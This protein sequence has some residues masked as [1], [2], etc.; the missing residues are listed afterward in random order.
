MLKSASLKLPLYLIICIIS[1]SAILIDGCG[2]KNDDKTTTN[3][4]GKTNNNT[5]IKKDSISGKDKVQLKYVVKKGDILR[6]KMVAKTST[7]ENSPAT[8]NKEVKQDN[9]INYYYSKE[10]TD[11]DQNGIITFKINFDSITISSSMGDQNV[12]YNS[13]V[14]D[15]VKSNPAFIQYNAVIREPFYN[16]VSPQGEITDVYGLEKIYDNLFKAFGDT[17]KEADKNE[18]KESF[19]KESIKEILQQEY[20]IFPAQDVMVDSSWV[21]SYATQLMV[22]EI[23]NNAKYTLKGIEDKDNSKIA[24]IEAVLNV[25]FKNKEA[26][27]KG[28][29][30]KIDNAQTSGTGKVAFNLNKG[31][32]KNKET[33]TNLKLD[34][35]MSAQGQSA[36]SIQ[37]V[38]TNLSVSLLN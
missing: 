2:K 14:N 36:T 13:N 7:S 6:Y 19:G 34:L 37:G 31:C 15:T 24:N 8:E 21:K 16:R 11:I 3:D 17:L 22:F 38:S 5:L 18:I 28:M 25:E 35:K 33:T 4:T 20:Q 30:I 32:V 26:T 1:L 10:V 12:K 29:K 9:E 27:Q 23:V